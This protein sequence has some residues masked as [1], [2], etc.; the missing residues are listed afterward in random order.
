VPVTRYQTNWYLFQGG[1]KLDDADFY[2]IAGSVNAAEEARSYRTTGLVMTWLGVGLSAIGL[3]TTLL[4]NRATDGSPA[5][6]FGLAPLAAGV[7]SWVLGQWR[8]APEHHAFDSVT[9]INTAN[10]Y[11]RR[12]RT[13]PVSSK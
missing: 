8:L 11:N 6:W 7:V 4:L 2:A 13:G 12:L 3:G 10:A 9:A 1:D 5:A